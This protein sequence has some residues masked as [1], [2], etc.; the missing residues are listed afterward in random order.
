MAR[1][2]NPTAEQRKVLEKNGHNPTHWLYIGQKVQGEDGGR[3]L[4]KFEEKTTYLI[5]RN[6]MT[7][8]EISLSI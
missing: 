2:K 3:R 1:G 5:F 8:R 7:E 4:G 6:R